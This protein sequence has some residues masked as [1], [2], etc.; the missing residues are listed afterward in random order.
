MAKTKKD[1]ITTTRYTPRYTLEANRE[2]NSF[3]LNMIN[4]NTKAKVAAPE[5]PEGK[6]ALMVKL[7]DTPEDGNL[8]PTVEIPEKKATAKVDEVGT[9]SYISF[10]WIFSYLW[11]A[12]KG[13]IDEQENWPVSIFDSANLNCTRLEHLWNEEVKINPSSPSLFKVILRFMRDRLIIACVIFLFCLIFGFIGPTCLVRGLV[14]FTERPPRSNEEILYTTGFYLAIA[15]LL[16]EI[17]RVLMYGATW[18]ISYRTGIRVRGAVLTLLYKSLMNSKTLR[19]KTASEVVNIFA[20][21]G[22]RIFDAVTFAPLVLMGPFVIVGG[23]VYLVKV[24]GLW[25]LAGLSIFLVF[26]A[27]QVFLGITLVRCRN[28]A[29]KKTEERMYLMGEILKNIRLIKMN[30]WEDVFMKKVSDVRFE[31][32]NNLQKAGYAQSLAIASGTIVPVVAT[33]VTVVSVV[34]YGYDILASDIFSAITVFFVMLFGIRMIPYGARYLAEARVAISRIQALLLFDKYQHGLSETQTQYAVALK[35]A[36]F[37]FDENEKAETPSEAEKVNEQ[38]KFIL[39]DLSLT[40]D[41]KAK[42][43]ICGP[44]GSGKSA[45]LQALLGCMSNDKGQVSIGGTVGYVPS[46]PCV[47]NGT[48][49]ENI[50]FGQPLNSQRYSKVISAASLTKDLETLPCNEKSEVGERGS[51]LSGGQKCRLA[52]A[53]AFYANRDIYLLD[54]VFSSINKDV[55]QSIFEK[56]IKDFLGNKTVL[57]VTSNSKFLEE[58]DKVL[59]FYDGGIVAE[60]T[61]KELVNNNEQYSEFFKSH[62]LV[63]SEEVVEAKGVSLNN[64]NEKEDDSQEAEEDFGTQNISKDVYKEYIQAAGGFA[65]LL[66]LLCVFVINVGANIFGTL[67]LSIWMKDVHGVASHGQNYTSLAD[68]SNLNYYASIYVASIVVLF[69]SGL[70]KAMVFVKL[71]I[72]ASTNL[73]LRMLKSVLHGVVKFFDNTPTGRILNRFSKDVD[74]IDVK[75]PFSAEALLQ[76]FITCAGLIL[77]IIWV[78]PLL[79]V[80]F[81]PLALIFVMFFLCFRAGIRCLKRSENVSRSPVFDHVTSSLEGLSTVH[82]YSQNQRFVENFKTKLDDNSSMMFMYHSAM[83][84]QAVWL[85]LLVV[86]ISFLVSC[87]IVFLTGSVQPSDA[88]MALAFALQMSGIFQFAVRSQ[89]EL[90]AKLTS[91]E[92]V[93]YYYKNIEQEK[94]V[95]GEEINREWPQKGSLEFKDVTLRYREGAAAALKDVSFMLNDKDKVLVIG[96]TGSGKSSIVNVI[97][98]LYDIEKGTVQ[99]DDLDISKIPLRTLRDS[100]TVIPQDGGLFS[101][102]LRFNLDPKEQYSDT[103]YWAALDKVGLKDFVSSTS[104]KLELKIEDSGKNLSSGQRQLVCLARALLRKSKLVVLDEATSNLD[105]KS[106]VLLQKIIRETFSDFSVMVISHRPENSFE[107]DRVLKVEDGETHISDASSNVSS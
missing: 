28:E 17:S 73:H 66:M 84:W 4:T 18:A 21:D 76:Y 104:E 19:D 22:Q 103:D 89:T 105:V 74:E 34:Y 13:R 36:Y 48:V 12:Y 92:R 90:E 6:E 94:W 37:S 23:I 67:W 46:V 55:A 31:E 91:V 58:C 59:F 54:D 87:C 98:R 52:L 35:D 2:V 14:S 95:E 3:W 60:G 62:I 80:A 70:V 85:D 27:I 43:G 30:G 69:V 56:G 79:L 47:L 9:L 83:R 33:V 77:T 82:S 81:F 26:D 38:N 101:G 106:D 45:F 29:I 75:L 11:D 44:V 25:S 78:F 88:G 63:D 65:V 41:R 10:S 32:K 24:I 64:N 49:R 1:A 51:K 50:L 97:F 99:Y 61:H 8:L 42:I 71:S 40:V 102:S 57:L 5:C 15:I 96:R 20:N 53:R 39:H 72:K 7:K 16:V 107:V 93:S 68:D 100:I 86:A